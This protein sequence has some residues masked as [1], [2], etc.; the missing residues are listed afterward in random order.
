MKRLSLARYEQTTGRHR[1]DADHARHEVECPRC[2]CDFT[3]YA[4]IA[5]D[6]QGRATVRVERMAAAWLA[7][8]PCWSAQA[9]PR[10]TRGAAA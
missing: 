5:P 3:A 9:H 7:S 1:H 4:L 6:P 10:R 8:H 2:H